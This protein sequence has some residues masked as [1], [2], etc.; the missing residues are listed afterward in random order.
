MARVGFGNRHVPYGESPTQ[1]MLYAT[2]PSLLQGVASVNSTRQKLGGRPR[3]ASVKCGALDDWLGKRP[4]DRSGER[5]I[6]Q[7]LDVVAKGISTLQTEFRV[8]DA[9]L[10]DVNA[11]LKSID[12]SLSEVVKDM[13]TLTAGV[14]T[15]KVTGT[16]NFW[17]FLTSLLVLLAYAKT[18]QT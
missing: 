8:M 12:A 14:A 10:T 3:V 11:R 17:S 9:R 4:P 7:R 18:L 13:N 6:T 16:F 2:R 15:A 1:V 5:S